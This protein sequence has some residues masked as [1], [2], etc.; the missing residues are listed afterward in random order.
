MLYLQDKEL[1]SFA[2]QIPRVS[3]NLVSLIL[4]LNQG[5]NCRS[6]L[7]SV[8]NFLFPH[9]AKL[10][11][12]CVFNFGLLSNHWGFNWKIDHVKVPALHC[13]STALV[14]ILAVFAWYD[15]TI[16]KKLSEGNDSCVITTVALRRVDRKEGRKIPSSN[17]CRASFVRGTNPV[18]NSDG[19]SLFLSLKW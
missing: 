10:N 7:I 4:C 19:K 3:Q 2:P 8:H 9:Q 12:L 5:I 11:K 6:L 16:S 18:P 14:T 1:G 17:P 15:K 13:T